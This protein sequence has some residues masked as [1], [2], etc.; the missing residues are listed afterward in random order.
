M[1]DIK[2]NIHPFLARIV[3]GNATVEEQ[4]QFNEWLQ[5]D[6][7]NL[8]EFS[9]YRRLWNSVEEEHHFDLKNAR[10][11][12]H[13]KIKQTTPVRT[14]AVWKKVAV[15]IASIVLLIGLLWTVKK[16]DNEELNTL[17]AE[18]VKCG[19]GMTKRVV[20]PDSTIVVLN[21]GSQLTFPHSFVDENIRLVQLVGEGLFDVTKNKK[22]P[23]IVDAG[24]VE[25]K[26]LGTVFNVSNY[27]DDNEVEV[28]LKE[29]SVELNATNVERASENSILMVPNQL[30]RFTNDGQLLE[31]KKADPRDFGTWNEGVLN[32]T[33]DSMEEVVRKLCRK[34]N[35]SIELIKSDN[36]TEN[37]I[38]ARFDNKS[39]EYVLGILK[40]TS[41]ISYE[42]NGVD[43]YGKTKLTIKTHNTIT[44]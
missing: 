31:L 34:Y 19:Y 33:N 39:L 7:K 15:S 40:I 22:K 4:Q 25:V 10:K 12:V 27:S 8:K 38:T 5:S 32:F 42:K 18:T 20:L 16:F 1:K 23:F 44:N 36:A 28:F 41:S 9:R 6:P 11:A 26:V 17:S 29:G 37:G 21:A 13:E 2:D 30:A 14:I 35:V 43:E 24:N 3:T